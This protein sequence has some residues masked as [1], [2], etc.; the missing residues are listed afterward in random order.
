MADIE[1][2]EAALQARWDPETA[3]VYADALIARGDPRGE[4]IALDLHAAHHG[5]TAE[6]AQQRR[7]RAEAWL[8]PEQRSYLFGEV[9]FGMLERFTIRSE[10]TRPAARFVAELF[11]SPAAP[12]LRSVQ[13]DASA[14][15][16]AAALQLLAARPLP[17]LRRLAITQEYN[18]PV[19]RATL[20]AF[21]AAA[22]HLEELS[23]EGTRVVTTPV[24]P[25]VRTLQI[26]GGDALVVGAAAMPSVTEIDL[27]FDRYCEPNK[28]LAFAPLLN[29]RLFPALERLDL[30]RSPGTEWA[31]SLFS[32]IHAIES[33]ERIMQLRIP[34]LPSDLDAHAAHVLLER[35]PRLEITVAGMYRR[36]LPDGALHPR[37]HV[38]AT[39]PWPPREQVPV[40]SQ[41]LTISP[42][43]EEIMLQ[44]CVDLLEEQFDAMSPGAQAAWAALWDF[45]DGLGWYHQD[46]HPIVLPFDAATLRCALEAL[47]DDDVGG[48]CRRIAAWL[49]AANLPPGATLMLQ[50]YD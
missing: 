40:G 43:G 10:R 23:L 9:R 8:G 50:R 5:E 31:G 12:Y 3:M 16:V 26:V 29:P 38:P 19:P 37:L 39:R 13:I 34:A 27:V 11:A 33:F 44:S 41:G 46:Y 28:R 30:S 25:N 24:H 7:V 36:S 42:P 17:W 2:L 15:Q 20:D 6:L 1:E 48:H 47:D 32:F 4:L 21:A 49:R 14:K 18:G 35:Y 45:L 22:P